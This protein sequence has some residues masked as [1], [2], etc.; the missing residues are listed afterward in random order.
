M[1]GMNGTELHEWAHEDHGNVDP[2]HN[3]IDTRRDPTERALI[4]NGRIRDKV[5]AELAAHAREFQRVFMAYRLL[6]PRPMR[7]TL[8]EWNADE[9][10]GQEWRM[11]AARTDEELIAVYQTQLADYAVTKERLARERILLDDARREIEALREE[12]DTLAAKLDAANAKLAALENAALVAEQD[13]KDVCAG[14]SAAHWY[15]E[16]TALRNENDQMRKQLGIPTSADLVVRAGK[17]VYPLA[18]QADAHEDDD[19]ATPATLGDKPR[20]VWTEDVKRAILTA[21]V[22]APRNLSEMRADGWMAEVPD[23][24]FAACILEMSRTWQLMRPV[25]GAPEGTY[26]LTPDGADSARAMLADADDD[27]PATLGDRR[28]QET[29]SIEWTPP[30]RS[31]PDAAA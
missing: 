25:P 9:Q 26:E 14:F 16:V 12:R 22:E 7:S 15:R 24:Q 4:E 10:Y 11:N 29:R 19:D 3:G 2:A 18:S 28:Q 13:V 5:H 31:K 23:R 1:D 21:L 20:K 27:M 30:T 8:A 17:R 6:V